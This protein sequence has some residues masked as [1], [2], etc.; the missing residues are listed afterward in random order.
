MEQFQDN[1]IR[2]IFRPFIKY[3]WLL[4]VG[5]IV[6]LGVPR[7]MLVLNASVDKNFSMVSIIFVVMWFIP[8][9]LLTREGRKGI[10]IKKPTNKKWLVYS[11]L[12]GAVSSFAVYMLFFLFY[13]NTVE[14][15][16][17]YIGGASGGGLTDQ[18]RFVYFL[19]YA[20]VGMTFSPIGEEF[21]YRGVI[22]G[23]FVS[24][25][26]EN[27]ASIIDSLAFGLTH[28]AHFGVVFVAGGWTFFAIPTI[29][30]VVAMF[31]VSRLFFICK[32]KSG[33]LLGA[34]LA[35]AAY[36]IMMGFVIFYI[37]YK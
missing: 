17:V 19:I 4:G 12:L 22:H 7:F 27:R 8:L 26:G 23:A 20:V 3:N 15:A 6:L 32:R 29:L 30:W 31:C 2:P 18:T 14:N 16:Y 13:A 5:M 33:S 1:Y 21:V 9:I 34:I 25:C 24:K 35:H 37:I 28:I 36:N 10:G 11:I